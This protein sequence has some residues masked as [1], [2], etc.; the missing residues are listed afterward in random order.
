MNKQEFKDFCHS[1]FIKRG[2]VKQRSMY[3]IHGEDLLCGI[4]M[5]KSM[6][7]AYYVNFYFF[8]GEYENIKSYPKFSECDVY[9][10]IVVLSKDTIKG[11]HFMTALIDY[12][13]YT[14]E[15][16]KPYFDKAFDEYIMPP[17]LQG[18]RKILDKKDYYLE[19]DLPSQ[20]SKT[21][22]KLECTGDT[23]SDD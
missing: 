14:I 1:E 13:K 19:G 17:V 9:Q 3:Y 22:K 23:S 12:E 6:A 11:E 10:R 7:E 4:Y 5:Q 20:I 16:I 21:M 18:K 15:E 8:I 2:F